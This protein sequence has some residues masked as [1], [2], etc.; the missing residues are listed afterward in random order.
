[1]L[2]VSLPSCLHLTN[3]RRYVFPHHLT[4]IKMSRTISPQFKPH[5][6]TQ[7]KVIITF[8]DFILVF[9]IALTFTMH[10][11]SVPNNQDNGN[12]DIRMSN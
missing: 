8:I 9:I 1:M 12:A 5:A 2:T 11:R 7:Q 6:S 3:E 10:I 4:I